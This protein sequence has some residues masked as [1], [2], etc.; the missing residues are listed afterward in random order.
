MINSMTAD[1]VSACIFKTSSEQDHLVNQRQR[2]RI[3]TVAISSCK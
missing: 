1:V 3:P 2:L